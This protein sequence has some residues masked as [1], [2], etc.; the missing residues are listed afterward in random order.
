MRLYLVWRKADGHPRRPQLV[1]VDYAHPLN[2]WLEYRKTGSKDR[3][4]I[5][6][7]ALLEAYVEADPGDPDP[8]TPKP[9]PPTAGASRPPI[10]RGY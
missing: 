3:H 6:E 1:V 5:P 7:S 8:M 4:W 9:P 2:G 10:L